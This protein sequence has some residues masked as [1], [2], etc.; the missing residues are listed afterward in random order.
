MSAYRYE[1]CPTCGFATIYVPLKA[2]VAQK[3]ATAEFLAQQR[4]AAEAEARRVALM[5]ADQA[6]LDLDIH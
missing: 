2:K 6:L 3:P 4:A 1:K 5:C